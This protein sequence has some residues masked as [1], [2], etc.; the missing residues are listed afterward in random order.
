[1]SRPVNKL[2]D[3]DRYRLYE[4]LKT[5]RDACAKHSPQRIAEHATR[6]L[7]TT[8]TRYNVESAAEIVGVDVGGDLPRRSQ[9]KNQVRRL[10]NIMLDLFDHL[11]ETAPADLVELAGR[12]LV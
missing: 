10:A 2:S 3:K 7:K 9:T 11:G 12:E 1:M 6:A 5:Y 4:Y 8:I